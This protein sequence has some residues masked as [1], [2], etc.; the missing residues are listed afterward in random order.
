[1]GSSPHGTAEASAAAV[2]CGLDPWPLAAPQPQDRQ[3]AQLTRQR[4]AKNLHD[5]QY[6]SGAVYDV[7]P[8]V[9][10][11]VCVADS[12]QTLTVIRQH[13][14]LRFFTSDLHRS[15]R[16]IGADFGPVDLGIIH[17]FCTLVQLKMDQGVTKQLVYY[18]G[19]SQADLINSLLLLGCYAILHRGVSG[20]DACAIFSR[21]KSCPVPAFRDAGAVGTKSTFDVTL[22]DCLFGLAKSVSNGWLSKDASVELKNYMSWKK[23]GSGDF[24]YV[25]PRL[26]TFKGPIHVRKMVCPGLFTCTPVDYCQ[27]FVAHGVACVL[28]I[29]SPDDYPTKE[30]EQAG[31]RVFSLDLHDE[32]LPSVEAV[33]QARK[34][35]SAQSE[36][37][38]VVVHS[39]C[40]IR[41]TGLLLCMHLVAEVGFTATEAIAWM[42][43]VR[44][45]C[46]VGA[47]QHAVYEMWKSAREPCLDLSPASPKQAVQ[48]VQ[49]A[50]ASLGLL[51]HARLHAHGLDPA[52]ERAR[53]SRPS[54]MR[55]GEGWKRNSKSKS[56]RRLCTSSENALDLVDDRPC[57]YTN[58]R[59]RPF[60]YNNKLGFAITPRNNPGFNR[61]APD[62]TYRAALSTEGGDGSSSGVLPQK[63][64]S[65]FLRTSATFL[66]VDEWHPELRARKNQDETGL[67]AIQGHAAAT[68]IDVTDSDGDWEVIQSPG[69]SV[70]GLW[71]QRRVSMT[72]Y[73]S[74]RGH[75][76]KN[77]CS[78][79]RLTTTHVRGQDASTPLYTPDKTE[80]SGLAATRQSPAQKAARSGF[81][82]SVR[83]S[84]A[85]GADAMPRPLAQATVAEAPVSVSA[86][87]S[88]SSVSPQKETVRDATRQPRAVRAPPAIHHSQQSPPP[89]LE[90]VHGR[91]PPGSLS[92]GPDGG[93][94]SVSPIFGADRDVDSPPA[95]FPSMSFKLQPPPPTA[96][97]HPMQ[98][99]ASSAGK[100]SPGFVAPW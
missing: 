84:P 30:L 47:Q 72:S 22:Q 79:R 26:A 96:Y 53:S 68:F 77:S 55:G 35:L 63:G 46:L 70:L 64:F 6:K 39:R 95:A 38:V 10:A 82:R 14:K 4:S 61:R 65:N 1:M 73:D 71:G 83:M 59:N 62:V 86:V 87:C 75:D 15:Y 88:L 21:L 33:G 97:S 18:F 32:L 57:T 50:R 67:L 42:R 89:G 8:G 12:A 44:P 25:S 16:P 69:R 93:G 34:I 56:P 28:R 45:G 20:A 91:R 60:T 43:M 41:A 52:A 7:V 74:P 90:S 54:E 9:L 13:P 17:E 85:R 29:N 98:A 3:K 94:A 19:D 58:D 49:A 48:S 99:E 37:G 11:F 80:G 66:P 24:H 36:H 40:G 31:L 5:E 92:F 23:D 2:P 51:V 27:K 100:K 81:S 78:H 76:R